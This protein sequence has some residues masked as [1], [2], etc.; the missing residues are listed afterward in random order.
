MLEQLSGWWRDSRAGML[1]ILSG[2]LIWMV[3]TLT[4]CAYGLDGLVKVP[5]E[6]EVQRSEGV[7]S[8]LPLPAAETAF[9]NFLAAGERQAAHIEGGRER[10]GFIQALVT[11]GFEQGATTLGLGT[12]L[13]GA[14]LFLGGLITK[15]PGSSRSE[16]KSY[17][18]GFEEGKKA[19]EQGAALVRNLKG[20]NA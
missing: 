20:D 8:V 5:V 15:G 17:N 9:E 6:P 10:L 2:V 16:K 12:G 4:G 14:M 13:G 3:L 1:L 18:K 7:P 19:F 11:T